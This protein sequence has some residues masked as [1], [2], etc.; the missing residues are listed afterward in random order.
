MLVIHKE[1]DLICN[2]PSCKPP[3]CY[4][5]PKF[6]ASG[7][8]GAQACGT[9][10]GL[11]TFSSLKAADRRWPLPSASLSTGPLGAI[12]TKLPPP[13][14]EKL[15][16]MAGDNPALSENPTLPLHVNTDQYPSFGSRYGNH[17]ILRTTIRMRLQPDTGLAVCNMW[18]IQMGTKEVIVSLN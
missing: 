10:V 4:L 7:E 13:H 16:C 8:S 15:L 17:T 18:K 9:A 14:T 3:F 11:V 1:F 2:C 6:S 5:T 12:A